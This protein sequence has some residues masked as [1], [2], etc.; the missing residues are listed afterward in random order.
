MECDEEAWPI[1]LTYNVSIHA[2]RVECDKFFLP[3]L[4][5]SSSFN[6][7]TPCGVRPKISVNNRNYTRFQST[8]SV[9]SATMINTDTQKWLLVSI[10]ALRVE[11]DAILPRVRRCR[12]SFNPRTP[13]GVRLFCVA[14]KRTNYEF[15]S[16]HSVWSATIGANPKSVYNCGFNPRTP[17]GVR[18]KIFF[19]KSYNTL[20]QS[21]HSVWSATAYDHMHCYSTV[22]MILCANLP[23]KTVI[24]RPPLGVII[25]QSSI[26]NALHLSPTSRGICVSLGLAQRP[27]STV[28][29]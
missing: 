10:H 9:W 22:H 21:T 18:L 11:C 12:W 15:Q 27:C 6:P 24:A 4:T 1:L 17:C 16:T 3:V 8:H 5:T 7:R 14:L 25:C 29:K 28:F 26:P 23:E 13:C 2:L 19:Q 20:F